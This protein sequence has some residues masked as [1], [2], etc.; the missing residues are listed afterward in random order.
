MGRQRQVI[1]DMSNFKR[2]FYEIILLISVLG[3]LT[4]GLAWI[5]LA[6]RRWL[7][8]K[9]DISIHPAVFAIPGVIV[10]ITVGRIVIDGLPHKAWSEYRSD[11]AR[12]CKGIAIVLGVLVPLGMALSWLA[13]QGRDWIESSIGHSVGVL[14]VAVPIS[15]LFILFTRRFLAWL[16]EK[17]GLNSRSEED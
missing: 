14:F 9:L 17:A 5:S 3:P 11:L 15:I 2:N 7:E 12:R 6:G 4:L 8:V 13:M 10:L 16:R 1:T